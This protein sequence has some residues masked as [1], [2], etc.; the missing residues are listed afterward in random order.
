MKTASEKPA[1]KAVPIRFPVP[2][3]RELKKRAEKNRRSF[4]AEVLIRLERLF[5]TSGD[6]EVKDGRIWV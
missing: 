4:N 2:L 1:V 5:E 3:Y 6:M